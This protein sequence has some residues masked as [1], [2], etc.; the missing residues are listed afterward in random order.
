VRRY[1]TSPPQRS[2]SRLGGSTNSH[3]ISAYNKDIVALERA[4]LERVFYVK[5]D[6]GTFQ[7]PPK[8]VRGLVEAR[9]SFERSLI[10]SSL[11][12]ASPME[13]LDFPG[14][15]QG[16]QNVRYT[17]AAK[18]LLDLGLQRKHCGIQIF[19]KFEKVDF[20][21]KPDAVP[22]V[23]SPRSPVY[24][25]ALG[26]FIKPIESQYYQ[27]L[28]Q[29]FGQKTVFKGMD[30]NQM[31]DYM[32]QKWSGFVDP[33]AVGLDASRFDQ[34]VSV[35]MLKFEHSILEAPFVERDRADLHKILKHQLFTRA[36]GFCKN[37]RL[38][39]TT[40]G[41]R[42]SG[43]MNTGLGNCILMCCMVHS[44]LRH[45]SVD[46]QL[47]NNGDDCVVIM[48]RPD[49]ERFTRGLDTWFRELGFNMKVEAPVYDLEKIEFCQQHP[50]RIGDGYRM[51][52]NVFS[53]LEKDTVS[54]DQFHS[55][56]HCKKWMQAVGD[57][58][59][60][61]CSGVPVLQEFYSMFR[62]SATAMVVRAQR[63]NSKR[64]HADVRQTKL[65]PTHILEKSQG[66]AVVHSEICP[67][68][69]LSFWLAFGLSPDEQVAFEKELS[70]Q[71]LTFST[72][73]VER[74]H[75]FVDLGK[76][77]LP[78]SDWLSRTTRAV[79]ST[80]KSLN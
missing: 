20:T 66:M 5:G 80:E 49:L 77:I 30:A 75:T 50:V 37:G 52:R 18:E 69:R 39:F 38:S 13:I 1:G 67:E 7:P 8:P 72:V 29:M 35:D 3:Y 63:Q 65:F 33:V 32:A 74:L 64:R 46:A 26:R 56:R 58:G 36:R 73:P 23:I 6:D 25:V 55:I 12:Y 31:G 2:V 59:L 45:C 54:L 79:H 47:A 9:L 61:L 16:S 4:V 60:A 57:G 43:D 41:G 10:C 48:E 21:A 76:Y 22:R 51:V 19:N 44:Y 24:N 70:M 53:V 34:H 11:K 14:L 40:K 68:A 27:A 71:M 62:R 15:Y 42:C 17:R 28:D 78:P